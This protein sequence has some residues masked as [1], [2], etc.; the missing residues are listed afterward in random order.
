MWLIRKL[1]LVKEIVSRV[2]V[3]HFQRYRLLSTPW[4]KIYLHKISRSDEDA[5]MHDHPWN[6]RT[7]LLSGSYRERY[8]VGPYWGDIKER[9]LKARDSVYHDQSDVH[10][11]ELLTPHVWTLV[12]VSGKTHPWGYQTEIGWVDHARYR[13]W[14]NA[15]ELPA[16][17][18]GILQKYGHEV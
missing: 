16:P 17:W 8:A 3:L 6:F 5:H 15:Q 12:F 18:S 7:T 1:F 13:M 10:K 4:F 9:V 11:L 2:G 14:K